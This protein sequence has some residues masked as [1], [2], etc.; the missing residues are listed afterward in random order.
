VVQCALEEIGTMDE[1]ADL[2]LHTT[3]SDGRWTPQDLV[4]QVQGAGIGLFAVTDHESLGS[5]AEVTDLVRGNGLR[6]LPGVELSA[7]IDEQVYHLLAYGFDVKDADLVHLVEDNNTRLLD[8]SDE[9]IRLLGRAGYP[10]SLDD[11]AAYTWDR[12]RGGWKGLNYLIDQ[13]IC[14][15]VRGYFGELF[16]GDLAL[17]QADFPSPERV[18][19]VARK[20][21]GVVILAHPGASYYNGIGRDRLDELVDMGLQGLECYSFHHDPASTQ[22]YLDYCRSR[23][24]LITGG[25]DC[26]GGFAGRALGVPPVHTG[27]LRLGEL[28]EKIVV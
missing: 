5:L 3:A 7:R 25:S 15:D 2:H 23:N 17:P 21:G 19:S 24:L 6:F 8:S 13:G 1:R 28:E 4:A 27:D 22:D 18:I 12:R 16:G 20:A 9:A 11:Y 26:H 10:V 14:R